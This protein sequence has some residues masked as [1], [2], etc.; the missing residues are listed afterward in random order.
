MGIA[1]A[2]IKKLREGGLHSVEGVSYS[3]RTQLQKIKGISEAKVEKILEAGKS[4]TS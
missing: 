3:S 2:D 4:H 1:S